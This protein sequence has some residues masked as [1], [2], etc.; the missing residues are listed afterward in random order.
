MNKKLEEKN[1]LKIQQ[2]KKLDKTIRNKNKNIKIDEE[3]WH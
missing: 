3:L 1:I 2:N